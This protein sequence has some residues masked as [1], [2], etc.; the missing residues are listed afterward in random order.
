MLG[1]IRN[2]HWKP[3]PDRDKVTLWSLGTP[4]S[5]VENGGIAMG[6]D[7]RG[8]PS[9]EWLESQGFETP[10]S[11]LWLA[12]NFEGWLTVKDVKLH[13]G[14]PSVA[15]SPAGGKIPF[16][17]LIPQSRPCQSDIQR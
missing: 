15:S 1:K 17:H 10:G 2:S 5:A 8:I 3:L 14:L 9:K 11:G 4:G 7:A 6:M 13:T 12:R 16:T